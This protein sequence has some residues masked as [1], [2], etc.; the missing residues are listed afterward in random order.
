MTGSANNG[1]STCRSDDLLTECAEAGQHNVC[2]TKDSSDPDDFSFTFKATVNYG[3]ESA[4]DDAM[5]H[6][7]DFIESFGGDSSSCTVGSWY[8]NSDGPL[9]LH[10]DIQ[11]SAAN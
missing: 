11:C 3:G 9:T 4:E 5:F 8:Q 1:S 7:R 10:V 2:V 6:S